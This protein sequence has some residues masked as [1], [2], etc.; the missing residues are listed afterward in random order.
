MWDGQGS[1]PNGAAVPAFPLPNTNESFGSDGLNILGYTFAAPQ[2]ASLNTY[3]AKTDYNLTRNGNHRLFL[4]GQLQDDRTLDAAEFPGGSPSQLVQNNSKGIAVG[5]TAV[6]S[7]TVINN[8][9]YGFLR[10]GLPR[11]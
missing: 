9:R 11:P 10:Q 2:P 1:L 4:R 7:N 8:L 5:Y 6:L 3:L